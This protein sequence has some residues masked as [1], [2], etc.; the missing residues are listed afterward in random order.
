MIEV[1]GWATIRAVARTFLETCEIATWD[2]AS[3]TMIARE[4]VALHPFRATE[5]IS[6]RRE[7]GNTITDQ[8]GNSV[9][10]TVEVPGF[11][12][13]LLIYGR[14][15]EILTEDAP[16]G[17]YWSKLKLKNYIDGKLGSAGALRNKEVTGTKLPGGYEWSVGPNK[18]RLYDGALVNQRRNVWL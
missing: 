14:L 1:L 13:N 17:D 2:A 18:I 12:F 7:T 9:P 15:E 8:F 10:E 4:D 11:H 3:Q 6:V 16:G 5:T